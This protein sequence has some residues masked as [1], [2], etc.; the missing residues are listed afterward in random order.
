MRYDISIIGK[1]VS[2]LIIMLLPVTLYSQEQSFEMDSEGVESEEWQQEYKNQVEEMLNQSATLPDYV[3]NSVENEIR[4]G[5]LSRD[6]SQAAQIVMELAKE[7]DRSLRMGRSRQEAA[8]TTRRAAERIAERRRNEKDKQGKGKESE[9]AGVHANAHSNI[10]GNGNRPSVAD[11]FRSFER[12]RMMDRRPGPPYKEIGPP[13][14]PDNRGKPGFPFAKPDRPGGK[15]NN[16]TPGGK[17]D[18]D[19]SDNYY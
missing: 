16:N 5:M 19:P 1:I 4:P 12:G 18:N 7:M 14:K 8:I 10:R 9:K 11:E 13:G 15:P 17:P 6:P 2:I 3:L